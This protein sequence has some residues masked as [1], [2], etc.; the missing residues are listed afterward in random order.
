[1]IAYLGLGSNLGDRQANLTEALERL[2]TSRVGIEAV[3]SVYESDPVG[4]VLDQPAFYNLVAR[5][6]TTLEPR[7]LLRHGLAV[8][9]A[10]GRDRSRGVP[11]GP[12][13]MDVDLLLAGELVRCW[14][15]LE[16][17]HPE[18]VKRAFVV[19]PLVELE[20]QLRDPR[21][22]SRLADRCE[23]LQATQKIKKGPVQ[24]NR[25]LLRRVPFP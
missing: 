11:R 23:D 1:M 10:M 14:P 25:S 24:M 4:P 21:D 9:A 19:L 5:V 8:E 13:I 15:E 22:G 17:P 16:L 2:A 20:P 7:Q 3:S 12:R 18:L 6:A